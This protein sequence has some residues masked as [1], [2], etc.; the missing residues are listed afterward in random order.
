MQHSLEHQIR[1]RAYHLWLESGCRDG[2]EH[3]HWLAAEQ[4]LRG[5]RAMAEMASVK[6]RKAPPRKTVRKPRKAS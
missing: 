1:E 5:A 2:N 4:E 6:P 3:L